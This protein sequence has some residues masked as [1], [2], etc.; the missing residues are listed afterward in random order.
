[1][2]KHLSDDDFNAHQLIAASGEDEEGAAEEP[3]LIDG[4]P[5]PDFSSFPPMFTLADDTPQDDMLLQNL[6]RG[7]IFRSCDA[8][9]GMPG[10][11]P[12][13]FPSGGQS[14]MGPHMGVN[15]EYGFEGDSI[16]QQGPSDFTPFWDTFGVDAKP[17]SQKSSQQSRFSLVFDMMTILSLPE[18]VPPATSFIFVA[19]LRLVF[20]TLME[21]L[22]LD[23]TVDYSPEDCVS[24]LHGNVSHGAY[25]SEFVV[26]VY[27]DGDGVFVVEFRKMRGDPIAFHDFVR[28]TVRNCGDVVKHRVD[29]SPVD[30]VR[31]DFTRRCLSLGDDIHGGVGQLADN[32][33][34]LLASLKRTSPSSSSTSTPFSLSSPSSS[35]S[36]SAAS[37]ISPSSLPRF[38]FGVGRE[39]TQDGPKSEMVVGEEARGCG[40]SAAASACSSGWSRLLEMCVSEYVDVQED[41]VRSLT[42]CVL[43]ERFDAGGPSMEETAACIVTLLQ[44][45]SLEVQ[46]CAATMVAFFSQYEQYQTYILEQVIVQ[47]MQLLEKP[48]TLRDTKRQVAKAVV[49]V[50][51]ACTYFVSYLFWPLCCC[52]LLLLP[53]FLHAC[54][55]LFASS[56]M[57]LIA[58]LLTPFLSA[59][60][61]LSSRFS[62]G[63]ETEKKTLLYI[64]QKQS[65]CSEDRLFQDIVQNSLSKHR[66]VLT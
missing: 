49:N 20:Q 57:I 15:S 21:A 53:L 44:S 6:D 25:S 23:E 24:A 39:M 10:D 18:Y 38:A 36:P 31:P 54:S 46:R 26:S 50:V 43:E 7:L 32:G 28:R 37:S 29:G 19:T 42:S 48:A 62:G 58:T 55:L 16:A 4:V 3:G 5:S 33:P 35:S 63:D 65:R 22:E 56:H 47:L 12:G 8:L 27:P 34:S 61:R 66:G 40:P 14:G 64:L 2:S 51:D 60:S 45:C 41:A 1:M 17:M 30:R 13:L 11:L 59:S 52:Y 9:S